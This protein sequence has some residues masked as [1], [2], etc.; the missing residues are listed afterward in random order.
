VRKP[1]AVQAGLL[2]GHGLCPEGNGQGFDPAHAL[3]Q[4]FSF[5]I[6][7]LDFYR[8]LVFNTVGSNDLPAQKAIA[9]RVFVGV[10][11]R[12]QNHVGLHGVFD[13]YIK[14]HRRVPLPTRGGNVGEFLEKHI[15]RGASNAA[16]YQDEEPYE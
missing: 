7:Q 14:L 8:V 12:H 6:C 11:D 3:A 13:G 4:P 5:G 9:K 10:A 2:K 15:G 1:E 16:K